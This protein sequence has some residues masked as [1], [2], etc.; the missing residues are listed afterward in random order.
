MCGISETTSKKIVEKVSVFE[1]VFML[2]HFTMYRYII[3]LAILDLD[4]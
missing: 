4:M 2:N 3:V 1:G